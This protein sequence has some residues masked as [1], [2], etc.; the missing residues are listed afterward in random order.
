MPH[1][2]RKSNLLVSLAV[3]TCLAGSTAVAAEGS[4]VLTWLEELSFSRIAGSLL[5]LVSLQLLIGF[6]IGLVSAELGKVAWKTSQGVWK[7][8]LAF[9]T[10][11]AQY[12]AIAA[13]LVCVLYFI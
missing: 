6:L 5:S 12:G 2:P 4:T 13:V 9:S 10:S 7:A 1:L 3:L 11:A 8:T